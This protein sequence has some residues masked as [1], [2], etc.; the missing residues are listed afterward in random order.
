MLETNKVAETVDR[1]NTRKKDKVIIRLIAAFKLLKG[2]LLFGLAIGALKLLNKDVALVLTQWI[3]VLHVDP[4][5]HFI[6]RVMTVLSGLDNRKLEEI[7]AGGFFYSSLL[8][9][10]GIGLL[11]EKKWAE[12]LT[13]IATGSFIPLEIYELIKRVSLGKCAALVINI[14]VVY[15]L[16]MRIKRRK[17]SRKELCLTSG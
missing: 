2:V 5:N 9:T 8:L 10:E 15:Y 1:P 14:L 7:C 16:F 17:D 4:E 13:V 3:A 12:Y 6:H 11:L